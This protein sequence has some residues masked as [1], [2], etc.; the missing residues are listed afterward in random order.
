MAFGKVLLCVLE[1]NQEWPGAVPGIKGIFHLLQLRNTSSWKW[2]KG[3][4]GT[5]QIGSIV[6]GEDIDRIWIC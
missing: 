4:D 5:V 3:S 2:P 6:I 1:S